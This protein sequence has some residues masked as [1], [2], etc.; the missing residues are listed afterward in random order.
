MRSHPLVGTGFDMYLSVGKTNCRV[1]KMFW[2]F[3]WGFFSVQIFP[4]ESY[5]D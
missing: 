2:G 3:G 5:K 4:T 1:L